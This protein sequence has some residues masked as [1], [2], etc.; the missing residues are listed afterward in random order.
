MTRR[1]PRR[2]R[3]RRRLTPTRTLPNDPQ[4]RPSATPALLLFEFATPIGS[5]AQ[6]QQMLTYAVEDRRPLH[7]DERSAV[8]QR[9]LRAGPRVARR[10]HCHR[11][12]RDVLGLPSR[13]LRRQAGGLARMHREVPPSRQRARH[14]PDGSILRRPAS[15]LPSSASALIRLTGDG[16]A[17]VPPRGLP[18]S[19]RAA[20]T[21]PAQVAPAH[22][23]RP[24]ARHAGP[25]PA[26]HR[27]PGWH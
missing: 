14:R 9:A 1:T 22:G 16:S 23:R 4:E 13:T 21:P 20:A 17:L 27:A 12:R 8:P 6:A 7:E 11:P 19:G 15:R 5:R 2:C 18:H 3:Q 25:D 10:R 24:D 26:W